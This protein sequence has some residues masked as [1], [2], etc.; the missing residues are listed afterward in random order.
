MIP[1]FIFLLFLLFF[2]WDN[3][4]V[5][6]LI[7]MIVFAILRYDTGWDYGMYEH[8]INTP[9]FWND[10]DT[11]RYSYA[12]RCLFALSNKLNMPHLTFVVA[13]VSTYVILY[14]SLYVMK[15]TKTHK[16]QAL[17]VYCLWNDFYLSSFSTLRQA[18]AMTIGLLIFALIQRKKYL[19][20]ILAYLVAI[21]IHSSAVILILLYPIYFLRKRLDFKW[22]CVSV[23]LMGIVLASIESVLTSLTDVG[24]NKYGIYLKWQDNYG[25]KLIY[26]NVI[27]A[28]YFMFVFYRDKHISEIQ[29]QCYF[30]VLSGVFGGIAIYIYGGS[31]VFA[32]MLSYFTIFLIFIFFP[33]INI[34]KERV[35]IRY[36]LNCLLVLF[37]ISYLIII[38]D[39]GGKTLSP[40]VP[41][42]CILFR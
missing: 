40:Y 5:G 9:S 24:L 33:S 16:L 13:N 39:G 37:F 30:M 2:Y 28:I 8:I 7:V 27:L 41:Y 15:L 11:S 14:Y 34:F 22:L 32:R 21:H 35:K 3:K 19:M 31:I 26:L 12:W 23:I 25:G 10:A 18:L 42:K 17:L 6:M 20:S 29:R 1:Y 38:S 4:P 36:A